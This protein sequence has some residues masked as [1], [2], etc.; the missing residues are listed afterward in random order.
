[1]DFEAIL[2][3]MLGPVIVF[4]VA[5]VLT[6][7][8]FWLTRRFESRYLEHDQDEASRVARLQEGITDPEDVVQGLRAKRALTISSLVRGVSV[9][10][11]WVVA[12]IA[13]LEMSGLPITS[14]LAVAGVAG[15]A[16]SFGAQSVVKDFISGFFILFERQFDVGGHD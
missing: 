2:D 7:I 11:I 14:L 8:V 1:M 15:I 13:I 5:V 10:T 4:V 9:A 3:V 16:L 12:I 6:R